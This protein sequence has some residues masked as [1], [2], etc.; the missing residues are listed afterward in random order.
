MITVNTNQI[1]NHSLNIK[2]K[3]KYI[4]YLILS[5]FYV[6][7]SVWLI[8]IYSLGYSLQNVLLF[9]FLTLFITIMLEI[10]AGMLA[11]KFG[12]KQILLLA[13]FMY[14]FSLIVLLINITM[15]FLFLSTSLL[16]IGNSLSTDTEEL[17]L[18]N[19][20]MHEN[21]FDKIK[22]EMAYSNIYSKF[23]FLSFIS[24]GFAE[25]IGSISYLISYSIPILL[26]AVMMLMTVYWIQL[27]SVLPDSKE[28]I[29]SIQNKGSNTLTLQFKQFIGLSIFKMI[30]GFI[31]LNSILFSLIIWFPNYMI[32]LK[33]GNYL[34]STTIGVGTVIC[35]LGILLSN[36]ILS[37]SPKKIDKIIQILITIIPFLL[38]FLSLGEY[39]SLLLCFFMI[40]T[41]YGILIP[42][43]RKKIILNLP[44]ENKTL[45][46]SIIGVLSLIIFVLVDILTGLFILT[47]EFSVYY[48]LLALF[49]VI[50]VIP[51]ILLAMKQQRKKI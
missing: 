11:E 42:Y 38:L 34:I 24:T 25:I 4:L 44:L 37:G 17:W 23:I 27:S 47:I 29:N 22:T 19:Q 41:I 21:D 14:F 10:P 13:Y 43:Y 35:G 15:P 8:F 7:S 5:R 51:V 45:F 31:M 6:F 9:N 30:F 28:K 18:Y 48:Q 12:H 36:K 20:L 16:G 1:I 32:S 50:F 39:F 40:Q 2:F 3:E 46:L 26:S 33:I 49:L